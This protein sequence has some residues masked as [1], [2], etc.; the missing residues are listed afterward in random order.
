MHRIKRHQLFFRVMAPL[1]ALLIAFAPLN[2]MAYSADQ[3]ETDMS[4]MHMSDTDGA[5]HCE[6]MG[7]TPDCQHC[8]DATHCAA[9]G[10][11]CSH[12]SSSLITGQTLC[13]ALPV[14]SY[15]GHY[16]SYLPGDYTETAL[17]PPIL[18]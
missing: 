13:I 8:D 15:Y 14:H 9:A 17:R 4:A 6:Q 5:M 7:N 12:T 1:L 3:P 10:H 16:S 18:G 2:G 11:S